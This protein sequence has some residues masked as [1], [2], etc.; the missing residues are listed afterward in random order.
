MIDNDLIDEFLHVDFMY[1][2]YRKERSKLLK[3]MTKE[4][5][6]ALLK[7]LLKQPRIEE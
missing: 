4:E 7:M 2:K 1:E 5:K 6:D 3:K